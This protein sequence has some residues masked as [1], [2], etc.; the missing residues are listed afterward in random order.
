MNKQ[1][2]PKTLLHKLG[3]Y[4]LIPHELLHVL[5]YRIIGKPCRYRWG[6]YEVQ[7]LAPKNRREKLF[8]LLLPFGV[9]WILGLLFH[10]IWLV[11]AVS[12]RMPPETYFFEAPVWHFALPVMAT[13]F[14]IYS[15]TAHQDLI[16]AYS[17][18][19]VYEAEYD[20][21]PNL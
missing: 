13:L 6:D 2:T 8:V 21:A 10:F 7:S 5:A 3:G 11:L 15:G 1:H 4:Y 16:D 19:F 14:L 20:D 18:L 17:W 12:T 9:C